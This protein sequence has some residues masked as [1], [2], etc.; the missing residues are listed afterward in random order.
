MKKGDVL[1]EPHASPS[2]RASIVLAIFALTSSLSAAAVIYLL[3]RTNTNNHSLALALTYC[4][5]PL[6]LLSFSRLH[7]LTLSIALTC[8]LYGLTELSVYFLHGFKTDGT[9]WSRDI[10]RYCPIRGYRFIEPR[11]RLARF[12]NG[13]ALFNATMQLNKQA[14]PSATDYSPEKTNTASRIIVLGD[15]FSAG[16]YLETPW[17]DAATVLAKETQP[18]NTYEFY[19]FSIDGG[20]I[21]NWHS[22]YFN[23]IASHYEYDVLLLAAFVDNLERDFSIAH[24]DSDSLKFGRFSNKPRDGID[25]ERNYLPQMETIAAIVSESRIDRIAQT[26]ASWSS[27]LW[28]LPQ[29]D[30][31]FLNFLKHKSYILFSKISN[32]IGTRSTATKVADEIPVRHQ[33]QLRDIIANALHN[34]KTVLLVAIPSREGAIASSNGAQSDHQRQLATLAQQYQIAFIDGYRAFSGLSEEEINSLWLLEDGHWNQNGS[35]R[36]A[37]YLVYTLNQEFD[38]LSPPAR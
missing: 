14:W 35:D 34:R 21:A 19:N 31:Y 22:V 3:H 18:K 10:V 8:A 26:H 1:Q 29:R 38:L 17:P 13:R 28:R 36:F 7:G 20:G 12:S 5:I 16:H 30:T 6:A 4:S 9:Y 37:H 27:T 23:E 11:M 24:S 32:R 15:S 25:F 2:R 33:S